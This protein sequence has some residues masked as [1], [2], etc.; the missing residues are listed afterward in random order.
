ME[1][2]DPMAK[3]SEVPHPSDVEDRVRQQVRRR[4]KVLFGSSDRLEVSVAV[5]L[6]KDGIVNATDLHWELMLAANRVRAQL[7]ALAA[8]DLVVETAPGLNGKRMFMRMDSPFW[9]F[10]LETYAAAIA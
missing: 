8:A 10:C 1:V 4:S 2:T 3:R 9:D 7:L 6:A 5:A